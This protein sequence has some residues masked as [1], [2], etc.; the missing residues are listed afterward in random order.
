MRIIAP[1]FLVIPFMVV[2]HCSSGMARTH[3][4]ALSGS[5]NVDLDWTI[6]DENFKRVAKTSPD[7][8][9]K[10]RFLSRITSMTFG[11]ERYSATIDFRVLSA[12]ERAGGGVPNR[13]IEDSVAIM[14]SRLENG[15]WKLT[16]LGN[17]SH[18]LEVKYVK[19][20][21]EDHLVF[22]ASPVGPEDFPLHLRRKN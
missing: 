21:S 16:I 9:Q 15:V 6:Q 14:D 8:M 7:A 22:T 3:Y 10:A 17:K 19:V 4:P 12:E 2:L 18:R 5:W 13:A 11:E 20:L 1:L